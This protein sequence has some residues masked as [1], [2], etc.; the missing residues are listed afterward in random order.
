MHIDLKLFEHNR[1]A[2]EAAVKL[3]EETRKAAVIHPTG[4]GKSFIAFQLAVD[5]PDKKLLWLSPNAYIYQTQLENLK[6]TAAKEA[7]A[8]A[9]DAAEIND[10]DFLEGQIQFLTYSKLIMN[11]EVVIRLQPD[12][13]VLDEFHRC[14]AAE[15]GRSV[16]KLLE[17]CPKAKVLGLSA[18]NIRYL[19]NQR[20]MA[21]ELFDGCIASRMT[22]GEAIAA[23]ILPVSTYVISMYTCE[24]HAAERG[25][26][27]TFGSAQLIQL[28]KRVQ[29][30]KNPLLRA[31]QETLLEQLRRSLEQADGLDVVFWR[32]MKKCGGKYIVF[33][34]GREHMS[35]MIA[36]AG[37]WFHL[38]D[39]EPHIYSVYYDNPQTS[40]DFAAFLEDESTHLKLLF[41]IDMLNEGVHVEGIDG[42]ILLR[43]TVSP[44]LYFQQ[45]GRALSAGKGADFCPVIF[46]VV[47]N[48]DS[49]CSVDALQEEFAE[50][51]RLIPGIRSKQQKYQDTFHIVDE[52]RDVRRLFG[53]LTESLNASWNAYYVQAEAYF[54]KNG[55]LRVPKSYVTEGGMN[56]GMW[57]SAQRRIYAGKAAGK[58]SAEQIQRLEAI[59]MDWKDVPKQRFL[60]G[61]HAL[62]VYK[63]MYGDTDVC[64]NYKTDAGYALGRWVS[65][66]RLAC[67]NGKLE[68]ERKRQLDALDMIWDVRKYRWNQ[69][70]EAAAAY[71]ELHGNLDVPSSYICPDGS[72]LSVWLNN[73]KAAFR[74][75]SK[76]LPLT[77]EQI[78]KLEAIGMQ[79]I[80]RYEE[81]WQKWYRLAERYYQEHG[82][83]RICPAYCVEGEPLGKWLYAVRQARKTPQASN[84]R[85][86]EE[87]IRKLDAI[88]MQWEAEE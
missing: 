78:Q 76:A 67:R 68:L 46:D 50:V 83:L 15:W 82:D 22:L 39:N 36:N 13:I 72:S 48:F 51:L 65:N 57:L 9:S 14:G 73:Q 29:A 53:K 38:V 64:S 24:N 3:M 16:R 45:I 52:L 79:W 62:K 71:Y 43:P 69:S 87:R 31:E 88:G 23:G 74:G 37:K 63:E 55:N 11:E 26:D 5:H 25:D 49:L 17:A 86:T 10:I 33:C 58:L 35:E 6:N 27:T 59:G 30:E 7:K 19:D 40:A 80:N 12:Y 32:H 66:Q 8:K 61:L 60:E 75:K 1:Q 34:A 44:I 42:V 56:L 54:E 21:E 20:D 28:E 84:R 2:Y 41:C 81:R 47:N 85:L 70:Y 18:T 77:Q 4:T